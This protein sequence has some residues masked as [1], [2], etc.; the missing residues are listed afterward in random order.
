[1]TKLYSVY[2]KESETFSA[3]FSMQTD[4]DAI[5]GF[6]HVV[7]NEKQSNMHKYP[8]DFT[9]YCVGEF[10]QR[11]GKISLFETNKKLINGSAFLVETE[12]EGE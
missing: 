3:P 7:K 11:E 2:D 5:E 12:I 4:R 10:S 8:N 9:L 6:K 1:M